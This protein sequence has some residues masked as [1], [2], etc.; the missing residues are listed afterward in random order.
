MRG[1][2]KCKILKQIRK[3][4]AEENDIPLITKECTYQG[5]CSGTCPRCEAELRYLE[6]QLARRQALGKTVTVAA[7][8]VSL[9]AGAVGCSLRPADLTGDVPMVTAESTD[10]DTTES[11]ELI[12]EVAYDPSDSETEIL[13]LDGDVAYLPELGEVPPEDETTAGVPESTPWDGTFTIITGEEGFDPEDLVMGAA[14]VP[15]DPEAC[16]TSDPYPGTDWPS[17]Q[18]GGSND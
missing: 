9:M 14:P 17:E 11:A 12:G 13:E 16:T 5:E 4:I 8:S 6:Q 3:Q 7:L 2:N 10:P 15:E 1:K 18:D